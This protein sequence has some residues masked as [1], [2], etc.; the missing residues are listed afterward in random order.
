MKQT[1]FLLKA[2]LCLLTVVGMGA[3]Q[4]NEE[5]AQN[6]TAQIDFTTPQGLENAAVSN[7][8]LT[9]KNLANGKSENIDLNNPGSSAV[10]NGNRISLTVQEGLYTLALE[11]DL[12]YMVEGKQQQAKA[13]GFLESVTLTAQT[14]QQPIQMNTFLY[15]PGDGTKGFVLAEVFFTGTETPE[16]KQ[17]NGDKYF[18]IYNNSSD[19][20]Y[21]DGLVIAESEFLTV[22]KYNYQ[23]DIMNEAVA[24]Q[25]IYRIP[26]SGK[27]QMV[28]PGESLLICDIAMDHRTANPNSFDLSKA[29]FEW[30]DESSNPNFA[31]TDT[32]V[33]NL[34]KIYAKTA[35]I[36]GPHN[37]G[38]T[39]FILARL[40]TAE[41]PLSKEEY[42][43][44]YGYQ[45]SYEMVI[46]GNVY[47]M[48]PFDSYK[49]PNEWVIDAVNCSIETQYEWIVTAPSLDQG[50]TH[51]G[52]VDGDKTRYGKS[53]RRKVLTGSTLQDT[54]N[55]TADFL[56]MQQADP[57]FAFH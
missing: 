24:V 25:A 15:N 32:E 4:K 48:G 16:G 13:R 44:Q 11:A 31:D 3:C 5:T 38:F 23:P 37:R 21:A 17:Y 51:C 1:N 50:W 39:A 2:L 40:G 55:S 56:P 54:N 53:I 42:L 6:V 7:M 18:R 47:P 41:Q 33:P 36:W 14:V 46:N 35:T 29:D 45:Y 28:L 9:V 10:L 34:E 30:Y 52:T 57:Y 19:T 20:L 22:K 12:S 27:D 26:G 49:I 8:T 43:S